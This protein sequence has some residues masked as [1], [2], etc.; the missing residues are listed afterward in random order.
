[1]ALFMESDMQPLDVDPHV[2]MQYGA[3]IS[4]HYWCFSVLPRPTVPVWQGNLFFYMEKKVLTTIL[5]D[6]YSDIERSI[7]LL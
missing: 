5:H 6:S 2:L 4:H 3:C 1:M 7:N